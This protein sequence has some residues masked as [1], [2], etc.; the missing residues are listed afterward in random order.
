M[1]GVGFRVTEVSDYLRRPISM[2]VTWISIGAIYSLKSRDRDIG[3]GE[4]DTGRSV[5]STVSGTKSYSRKSQNLN[6]LQLA[7]TRYS[8]IQQFLDYADT[9]QDSLVHDPNGVSLMTIHKAK[10]LEFPAV[11]VIGLVEGIMPTKK[12]DIEEERRICF[13][14][15]SRAMKLLYLS[16]SQTYLG[17]ASKKSIFIDEMLGTKEPT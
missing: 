5:S 4:A 14:G 2:V 13:V 3:Y 9:F 8:K 10:G 6:E 11:F 16:W 1:A 17:Q 12:G 15:I 7:A